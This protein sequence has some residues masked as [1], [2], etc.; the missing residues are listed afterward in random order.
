M[1]ILA[2]LDLSPISSRVAEEAVKLAR[3]LDE[4]LVL[5]HV[6]APEPDFIGYD[7]GPDTVRDA[8][9]NELRQEHRELEEWRQG[10][11][12]AGVR[13]RALMVQGPT[14]EKLLAQAER[15]APRFVVV[16]SHGHSAIRDLIAGSSIQGLLRHSP[17]PVVVVPPV[18][19]D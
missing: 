12:S 10:A 17:V 15:L 9:A 14:L 8:V 19:G 1:S 3:D 7:V 6:G 2:C 13:A 5:L 4:E 11:E 18:L 16:G